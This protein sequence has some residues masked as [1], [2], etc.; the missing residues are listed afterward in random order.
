MYRA[1]PEDGADLETCA[2][3]LS[4]GGFRCSD[5]LACWV[6]DERRLVISKETIAGHDSLWL[7]RW[8]TDAR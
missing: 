3:M 8:I 6:H 1:R 4:G 5:K 7:A 2:E